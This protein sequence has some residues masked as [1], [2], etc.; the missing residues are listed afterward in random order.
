MRTHEK[1]KYRDAGYGRQQDILDRV[2]D[3]KKK[4]T[5]DGKWANWE[6]GRKQ[7]LHERRMYFRHHKD[8]TDDYTGV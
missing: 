6:K 2:M 5:T 1:E 8:K 7:R 3:D 4:W